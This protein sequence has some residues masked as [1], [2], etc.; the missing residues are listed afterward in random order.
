[1]LGAKIDKFSSFFRFERLK[2]AL[3]TAWRKALSYQPGVFLIFLLCPILTLIFPTVYFEVNAR[4]HLDSNKTVLIPNIFDDFAYAIHIAPR[5][6]TITQAYVCWILIGSTLALVILVLCKIIVDITYCI[7][8]H[9]YHFCHSRNPIVHYRVREDTLLYKL[10][11]SG[12]LAVVLYA[13]MW[14]IVFF[15]AIVITIFGFCYVFTF[16]VSNEVIRDALLET[17]RADKRD[18]AWPNAQYSFKC[19]GVDSY[20]DYH[21]YSPP[22]DS[23]CKVVSPNC[24]KNALVN[25]TIASKL[26]QEGCIDNITFELNTHIKAITLPFQ[27]MQLFAINIMVFATILIF[28][29][30]KRIRSSRQTKIENAAATVSIDGEESDG[31]DGNETIETDTDDDELILANYND[32]NLTENES[33]NTDMITDEILNDLKEDDDGSE[34]QNVLIQSESNYYEGINN[35]VQIHM[36]NSAEIIFDDQL[37]EPLSIHH[38]LKTPL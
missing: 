11:K 26:H 14:V 7:Y 5:Y 35:E 32:S 30:Y 37:L 1:M 23:C 24:A 12:K 21:S 15:P 20:H 16:N 38:S 17:L 31:S 9:V 29:Y 25:P 27:A 13:G 28:K 19:C 22:D 8:R 3:S 6:K 10:S 4:L 33:V 2:A 18:P 34:L 36:E